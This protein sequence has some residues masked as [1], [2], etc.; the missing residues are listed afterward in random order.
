MTLQSPAKLMP[1]FLLAS[2][3]LF[4][5]MLGGIAQDSQQPWKSYQRDYIR[6]KKN[7]AQTPA[8][9]RAVDH[10][11]MGIRQIEVPE[12]GRV[13]RCTTCHLAMNH[14]DKMD[15]DPPLRR[16]PQIGP[17]SFEEFGCT[18]CHRGNGLATSV[19]A[20]H[21]LT[22]DAASPLL[23]TKFVNASCLACHNLN[24]LPGVQNLKTGRQLFENNGCLTCHALNGTGG[25]IGPALDGIG[26]RREWDWFIRHFKDPAS[27]SPGS[28]MPPVQLADAD[29][30]LLTLYVLSFVD[31]VSD[32]YFTSKWI[33]PNPQSGRELYFSR[34]CIGCH[35]LDNIGG[36]LGPDL[37]QLGLR[38]KAARLR[39]V[40]EYTLPGASMPHPDLRPDEREALIAFLLD[41]NQP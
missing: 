32:P 39:Y 7:S 4:I 10:F 38:G 23:P 3:V 29:L 31:P 17:H 25:Q 8:E 11:R 2:V 5:L 30:E 19:E 36:S 26:Q 41:L 27:V 35:Q 40:L 16:H 34:G 28:A 22:P 12:L 33:L 21:G 15:A 14:P 6:R 9:Q 37:S 13:D 24:A 20:A 18:V 1:W